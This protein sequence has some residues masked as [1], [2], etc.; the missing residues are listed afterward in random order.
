MLAGTATEVGIVSKALLFDSATVA[1]AEGAGPESTAVHVVFPFDQTNVGAHCKEEI[2]TGSVEAAMLPPVA[3]AV[4]D[5]PEGETPSVWFTLIVAVDAPEANV[6]FTVATTP[7]AMMLEFEPEVTHIYPFAPLLQFSALPAA[8]K[9]GPTV[10]E[11]LL[12]AVEG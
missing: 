11:R 6:T 4:M 9:A 1:P 10:T 12:I 2:V 8:L 3:V 7:F 5:W